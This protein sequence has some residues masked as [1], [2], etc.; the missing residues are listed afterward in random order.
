MKTIRPFRQLLLVVLFALVAVGTTQ[1]G[2]YRHD[3]SGYWDGHNRH[4]AYV[5]RHHHHGYWDDRGG[6]RVFINID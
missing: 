5:Y 3:K 2:P 1:A 4:H 6:S